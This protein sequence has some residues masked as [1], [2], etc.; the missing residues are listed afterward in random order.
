MKVAYV[1]T[2]YPPHIRGGAE[3]ILQA[4]V[5]AMAARGHDV[6]VLTIG[7]QP[8]PAEISESLRGVPVTRLGYRNRYFHTLGE[9]PPRLERLR[10]HWRD[11][12]N[13]LMA[14]DAAAALRRWMPDVVCCHNLSGWSI[15][16][17][18]VLRELSLPSMQVLHD[19][20][21]LCPN[22]MMYRRER[23]CATQCTVC[24]VM[25]T[26]H[27][28]A[29]QQLD[30]VV[31][32]SAFVLQRLRGAGFF[33]GVPVQEVLHNSSPGALPPPKVARS[34][35]L[36]F[37][38]IGTLAPAKGIELLLR[39][40]ISSDLPELRLLVAGRGETGYEAQLRAR[41]QDPRIEFAGYMAPAQFYDSIDV[42][43]VPSLWNDTLPSVV[44]EALGA[45]VPVV[46]SRRGG[47]PE[48]VR[49]NVNGLLFEP[50]GTESLQRALRHC[51][52]QPDRI[53]EWARHCRSSAAA[54][55]D[56]NAWAR[57]HED[58]LAATIEAHAQRRCTPQRQFAASSSQASG[59]LS[60]EG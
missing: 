58:L 59:V 18:R 33:D 35:S 49:D 60:C 24:R 15:A 57:R 12:H 21:L 45:G 25:R 11:R 10:W 42:C 41:F 8:G 30:A 36:R 50:D 53:V 22:S 1:N 40:I 29:S 14:A 32:V 54:F 39:A 31:G 28:V 48:M 51:I 37:G 17:W 43:V 56:M 9:A 55:F 4:Q 6:R 34:A 16:L 5:E 23:N 3:L 20:Y 19:Q 7:P 47:I 52:E 46:A 44:F 38:F 26:R 27:R 13:E 2:L